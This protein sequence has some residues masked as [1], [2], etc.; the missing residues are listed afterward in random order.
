MNHPVITEAAAEIAAEQP[1]TPKEPVK[2]EH[3]DYG[4]LHPKILLPFLLVSLI[5]GSTWL[6]I[7]DQIS[8]VPASWSVTYRFIIAAAGMFI[9]AACM[10]IPL[11]LDRR[12]QLWAMLIGVVQFAMNFNFVYAAEHHITSGLV[13][14]LF[15]LLIVPNALLGKYWL[16]RA[17]TRQFWIG[18]IIASVGVGLLVLRE[19]RF[20]DMNPVEVLIGTGLTLIAVMC[21]SV[22]N[23]LQASDRMTRFPI[24]AVLAWAMLYGVIGNAIWSLI[25]VGAPVIETR[26]AYLGGIVYLGLIGSVVTFPLYFGLIRDIGPGKAA[27]TS[28]F[29]PVVAMLLST[30]FEGYVWSALAAAGA[31]LAMAGLL[32]SMQARKPS[33]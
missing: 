6:V 20:A 16:G 12:G 10:R 23:V 25:T 9:L 30:L 24:I 32:I 26:A 15:A 14:V 22:S 3:T 19:Y 33:Q 8:A 21:A 28:V 27:Y 18:A 29:I 1:I 7:R 17:V 2:A 11:R 5:W 31:V 13:A 4:L